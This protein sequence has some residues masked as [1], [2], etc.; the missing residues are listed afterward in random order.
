MANRDI[1]IINEKIKYKEFLYSYTNQENR[2]ENTDVTYYH[3]TIGLEK[4]E[5]EI[6]QGDI[7]NH[8]FML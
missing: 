1:Q 2:I 5:G 8:K 4:N 3:I 7:Y 6:S